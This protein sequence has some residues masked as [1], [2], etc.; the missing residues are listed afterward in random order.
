MQDML[1]TK[2]IDANKVN[3]KEEIHTVINLIM[4]F[5]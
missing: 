3:N 2:I 1:L 5:V 4:E